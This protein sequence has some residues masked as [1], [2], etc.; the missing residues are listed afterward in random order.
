MF[1][2]ALILSWATSI[3]SS[4]SFKFQKYVQSLQSDSVKLN[5]YNFS[6]DLVN[7]VSSNQTWFVSFSWTDYITW[8]TWDYEYDCQLKWGNYID[9]GQVFTWVFC[10]IV[11]D[12][13][14]VRNIKKPDTIYNYRIVE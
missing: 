14:L 2:I 8:V 9:I 11:V 13:E 5:M 1:M 4:S 7:N 12:I 3:F 10:S 6:K